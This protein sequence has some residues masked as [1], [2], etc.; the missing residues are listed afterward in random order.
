MNLSVIGLVFQL[1]VQIYNHMQPRSSRL[2]FVK[3]SKALKN[4]DLK[5]FW[6]HSYVVL[7]WVS[8][9]LKYM[10]LHGF[11]VD[12]W[13]VYGFFSY[14]TWILCEFYLDVTDLHAM[15]FQDSQVLSGTKRCITWGLIVRKLKNIIWMIRTSNSLTWF[16]HRQ[17]FKRTLCASGS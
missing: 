6:P 4:C 16:C 1:N 15:W 17:Q 2:Q 12:F 10:I 11:Y 8:K 7:H 9:V 13:D 3:Y 14:F 5:M